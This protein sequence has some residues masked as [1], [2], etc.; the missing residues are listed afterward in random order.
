MAITA[1]NSRAGD[2]ERLRSLRGVSG[3][4]LDSLWE[5]SWIKDT[6]GPDLD[7]RLRDLDALAGELRYKCDEIVVVA[8]GACGRMIQGM[9]DALHDPE[10]RKNITVFGDTLSAGDYTDLLNRMENRNCGMIAV[11]GTGE[12]AALNTAFAVV[13]NILRDRYGASGAVKRSIVIASP[14]SEYLL[15][16]ADAGSMRLLELADDIRPEY[17]S[18]TA[19]MLVPLMAA[20][21]SGEEYHQ[22]FR[23]MAGSTWWDAD[24]DRY[25][26]WL[27]LHG[28]ED[29]LCWQK[30]LSGLSEWLSEV[31]RSAGIDSQVLFMP[32]ETRRRRA[33]AGAGL[34]GAGTKSVMPGDPHAGR[35]LLTTQIL[36]EREAA[37]VMLP[38][39]PGADPEGSLNAML[40]NQAAESLS[41]SLKDLMRSGSCWDA[42]QISMSEMTP[43][44]YGQLTAFLQISAGITEYALRVE[45]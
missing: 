39:F 5:Q 20:G 19:A 18:D 30:E 7:G 12:T 45:K 9:L 6:I 25:S 14:R 29:I 13:R 33:A 26:L 16:E 43:Y 22:G 34:T 1:D 8:E 40:A 37:D 36:M 35:G 32:G 2:P 28:A 4:A 3:A 17:A 24:A 42:S 38:A 41:P 23:E 10:D 31:H 21:V 11:A 15:K 27:S 44:E